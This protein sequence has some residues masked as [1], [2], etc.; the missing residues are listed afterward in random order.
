MRGSWR[1]LLAVGV[2]ACTSQDAPPPKPAP[3]KTNPSAWKE[4]QTPVPVGRKLPCSQLV[5]TDK[6]AAAVGYGLEVIDQSSRDP[7]ATSVCRLMTAKPGP[8]GKKGA[9]EPGEELATV[10]AYCWY[11]FSVPEFKQRC[12][13]QGEET[14]TD[15]G[16]LS[17]LKKVPA[18]EHTRFVVTTLEPDTRCK[19][20]VNPG[21]SNY[22]QALTT[23]VAKA[24]VDTIDKDSLQIK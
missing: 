9:I 11:A 22:D 13:D 18:G 21:P 3:K 4:I 23:Q 7:D 15:V 19:L 10:T 12:T 5:A 2:W 20:V 6:V 1:W 16:D 14:S 8:K 17:C 24:L